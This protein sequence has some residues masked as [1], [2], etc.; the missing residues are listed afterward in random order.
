M[1][2][3]ALKMIRT[4]AAG[5]AFAALTMG[6]SSEPETERVDAPNLDALALLDQ[7]N[8]AMEKM[9]VVRVNGS[10]EADIF[11]RD[12]LV[13]WIRGSETVISDW[14]FPEKGNG[15]L[16]KY[17]GGQMDDFIEPLN[18]VR[19]GSAQDEWARREGERLI[20]YLLIFVRP[21][22]GQERPP[23]HDLANLKSSVAEITLDDGR[24]GYE[25][26]FHWSDFYPPYV[27]RIDRA[28][29]LPHEIQH[30]NGPHSP[31]RVSQTIRL[32]YDGSAQ[33]QM[34]QFPSGPVLEVGR[35]VAS[36][37]GRTAKAKPG[38]VAEAWWLPDGQ[39]VALRRLERDPAK[40][41]RQVTALVDDRGEEWT[42][43]ATL[44][45]APDGILLAVYKGLDQ[46]ATFNSTSI[47]SPDSLPDFIKAFGTTTAWERILRNPQTTQ[48]SAS[49]QP[50][51]IPSPIVGEG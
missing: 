15:S 22:T 43:I 32:H 2:E 25:L 28:T 41:H 29:H 35:L 1:T 6:C 31:V 14:T 5:L 50:K 33:R 11:H 23:K 49:L 9:E 45:T 47:H 36:L 26:T 7:A 27:V 48:Q 39:I 20:D 34:A 40:P 46:K 3:G 18:L 44:A 30:G 24:P 8:A 21:W 4:A 16:R 10:S 51:P 13:A 12:G 38:Q 17:S 42:R 37:P 19:R